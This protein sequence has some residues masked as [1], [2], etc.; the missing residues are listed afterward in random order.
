MADVGCRY[1]GG[2][3][4][5][6]PKTPVRISVE[7]E[8]LVFTNRRITPT[9]VHDTVLLRLAA[10]AVQGA[11]FVPRGH[12]SVGRGAAGAAAGGALF[13]AAGA[14][15]GAVAFGQT[16]MMLIQV[17]HSGLTYPMYF[18]GLRMDN[19]C[20][21]VQA[22]L[23]RARSGAASAGAQRRGFDSLIQ[24]YDQYRDRDSA[25]TRFR[26]NANQYGPTEL[27]IA[28]LVASWVAGF[29]REQY[30]SFL[31]SHKFRAG[32]WVE[33]RPSSVLYHWT[34]GNEGNEELLRLY[35]DQG[36]GL[37]AEH[38]Y[39]EWSPYVN[40]TLLLERQDRHEEAIDVCL[41]ALGI[42]NAAACIQLAALLERRRNYVRALE[43]CRLVHDPDLPEGSQ[44][45]LEKRMKRLEGKIEKAI[46]AR[47]KAEEAAEK[48]AKLASLNADR[49]ALTGE[50][51]QLGLAMFGSKAE[52]KKRLRARIA[53][54]EAE[55][56][57][58]A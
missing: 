33:L 56:D 31:D 21:Q 39:V 2:A 19:V 30:E 29:S 26:E 48:E 8:Q 16:D 34:R 32:N 14:V 13:G 6:A 11:T 43:V 44:S 46:A 24:S 49:K 45:E 35:C 10:P 50:L 53:E 15:L 47:Q 5:L 4:F 55:M 22:M 37:A 54:L 57:G 52:R 17:T 40:L 18:D 9:G 12:T 1:L 3:P 7:G 27:Q 42:G 58:L 28:D 20:A 25:T 36:P 41:Q 38:A 23:S 51:E